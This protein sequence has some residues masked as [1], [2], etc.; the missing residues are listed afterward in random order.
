MPQTPGALHLKTGNAKMLRPFRPRDA[1]IRVTFLFAILWLAGCQSAGSLPT[2]FSHCS[3]E[4][5]WDTAIA[6]LEV[7]TLASA[8]KASGRVETAW[9]E[10]P[11][12][13]RAGVLG[14]DLN[15][16]RVKYVVEV[17]RDAPDARATVRQLREEWTP[18]GVRMRQW[19]SMATNPFEEAALATEISRRLK[20][21]GC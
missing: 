7:G 15:K 10:V 9:L 14:R 13:S 17:S 16:E 1:A 8:D 18:M 11:S 12:S 21:K 2:T 19:R 5:V 3:F 6:S 20:E 4:Q